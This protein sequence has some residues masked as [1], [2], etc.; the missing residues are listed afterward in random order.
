LQ[1]AEQAAVDDKKLILAEFARIGGS[2]RQEYVEKDIDN[3]IRENFK[4]DRAAF[5]RELAR[6]GQSLDQFRT[7]RSEMMIISVMKARVTNGITDPVA[8]KQAVDA[9]LHELRLKSVLSEADATVK[10]GVD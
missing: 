10:P 8:K 4:N 1:E 5:E 2:L 7:L 6:K 3:V 9:W